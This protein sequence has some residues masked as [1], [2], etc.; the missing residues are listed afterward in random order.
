MSTQ[1]KCVWMNRVCF[2]T[3]GIYSASGL[4]AF[5]ANEK[6]GVS[7]T[8]VSRPTGPGSIQ[9]LGESF[10][11]M[12]NTGTA[13]YTVPIVVP[14]ASA[15]STPVL[16][17]S[18]DGGFENGPMGFGWKLFGRQVKR[19][20]DRGVPLYQEPESLDTFL[21]MDGTELVQLRGDA[22]ANQDYFLSRLEASFVRYRRLTSEAQPEVFWWEARAKDGRKFEFGLSDGGRI[23][24]PP[25]ESPTG[26]ARIFSWLLER[27]T[28]LNGNVIE[29]RYS[30][31]GR[32]ESHQKYL[33]EMRYGPALRAEMREESYAFVVFDYEVRPDA[34]TDCRSGFEVK[35]AHRLTVITVG[36]TG[37][38]S[39]DNPNCR[40]GKDLNGDGQGDELVRRY[41]L[42]YGSLNAQGQFVAGHSHWSLLTQVRLVGCDGQNTLPPIAFRYA[43]LDEDFHEERNIEASDSDI[44][45]SEFLCPDRPPF[46]N[47]ESAVELVDLNSDGLTD[48]LYT[49]KDIHF[50][51]LNQGVKEA[52]QRLQWSSQVYPEVLDERH[53]PA[54][55]SFGVYEELVHLSDMNGDGRSDLVVGDGQ[56]VWYYSN[57]GR[58]GLERR[59]GDESNFWGGMVQMTIN[60]SAPP[61]PYEQTQVGIRTID[62]NFDKRIDIVQST[63]SYYSV[64]YNQTDDSYSAEKRVTGAWD[65]NPPG[66]RIIIG[67]DDKTVRLA[68]LNGDRL[69]DVVRIDSLGGVTYIT[70][71]ASLGWGEFRAANR[72]RLQDDVYLDQNLVAKADFKDLDGN[73]LSDLVVESVENTANGSVLWYW[74]NLGTNEFSKRR[75]VRGL[76]EVITGTKVSWADMNG[77][78]TVDLVYANSRISGQDCACDPNLGVCV[79]DRLQV[80]D[81]GLLI[82]KTPAPC[83]LTGIDNGIGLRTEISYRS[84]SEYFQDAL[85]ALVR[86]PWTVANANPVNVV[87]EILTSTALDLDGVSGVDVQRVK[88]SYRDGYYDQVRRQF[89][90]FGFVKRTIYGDE[91]DGVNPDEISGKALVERYRFHNGAPDGIDND[92]DSGVFISNGIDDDGDG[93]KDEPDEARLGIDEIDPWMGRE[94]EALKGI[95]LW[96]EKVSLSNDDPQTDGKPAEDRVIFERVATPL[97]SLELRVLS[98]SL[99]GSLAELLGEKYIP[100]RSDQWIVLPIKHVEDRCV[101]EQGRGLPKHIRTEFDVDAIGEP[102]Y[103]LELGEYGLGASTKDDRYTSFEYARSESNWILAEKSRVVVRAGDKDGPF[104]SDTRFYYDGEP[105]VGLPR[106]LLGD[107]ALLHRT[108]SF[109]SEPEDWQHK[110]EKLPE[111]PFRSEAVGDPRTPGASVDVSRVDYDAY[112]NVVVQLDANGNRREFIYDQLLHTHPTTEK[113]FTCGPGGTLIVSASYLLGL[114]VIHEYRDFNNNVTLY[115]YD[116]FGRLTSVTQ[117]LD[118]AAHPTFVYLYSMANPQPFPGMEPISGGPQVQEGEQLFYAYD[119]EG[120]LNLSRGNVPK[121]SSIQLFSREE[122]GGGT[123]D[124]VHYF[125]GAG[126]QLAHVEESDSAGKWIVRDAKTLNLRGTVRQTLQP[127]EQEGSNYSPPAENLAPSI[128]FYYDGMGRP[129]RV[130]QPAVPNPNG[131]GTVRN[132][133]EIVYLPLQVDAKDEEDTLET[134]LHSGTYQSTVTDGL[135]RTVT[136]IERNKRLSDP[137][138]TATEYVTT[139]AWNLQDDL[140]SV[141]DAFDNVRYMRYDGLGRKI[142][143]ND[144]DAGRCTYTYDPAGNVLVRVDAK[145]QETRYTYDCANRLLTRNYLDTTRDPAT[146]PVDVVLTYDVSAENVDQGDG[147]TATTL[148]PRGALVSIRDLSG[149]THSS[150]DA[151]GRLEWAV[152]IIPDPITG[153]DVAYRTSYV[154]DSLDRMR[155]VIYPDNDSVVFEYNQRS[156]LRS[157]HGGNDGRAI[158]KEISYLPSAKLSRVVAGNDVSIEYVYDP[159]LRLS[160]LTTRGAGASAGK[161]LI[162]YTYEFDGVSNL[163]AIRDRRGDVEVQD[164]RHNSQRFEYDDLYRLTAYHLTGPQKTSPIRQ[165]IQYRYDRIGNILYQGPPGGAWRIDS[166]STS[167]GNYLYSG[168][169]SGRAP[170]PAHP[171]ENPAGPHAV[172]ATD[173]GRHYKYDANG[174]ATDING[175]EASWDFLDQL[176]A[177]KRP[178]SFEAH[179]IYDHTGRRVV[180][181]VARGTWTDTVLYVNDVFEVREGEE[182]TKYVF[183][184]SARMARVKG[185]LDPIRPRIQRLRLT[186]G[187]NLVTLCVEPMDPTV[188]AVFRLGNDEGVFR[189]EGRSYTAMGPEET[190]APGQVLWVYVA[191]PRMLSIVGRYAPKDV[192]IPIPVGSTLVAWPRLEALRLDAV[193][194]QVD[195]VWSLGQQKSEKP[196]WF[197]ADLADGSA[198]S[199]LLGNLPPGV[200]VWAATERAG[201]LK[202]AATKQQDVVFFHSDHLGSTSVMTDLSGAVVSDTVFYPYG[203]TRHEERPLRW[204]DGNY[205][206][207]GKERD[208]E[209]HLDYLGARY[210]DPDLARFL[211]VDPVF[212]DFDAIVMQFHS[213]DSAARGRH[214]PQQLNLYSYAGNSPASNVDFNGLFKLDIH[215]MIIDE[216]ASGLGFNEGNIRALKSGVRYND[217]PLGVLGAVGYVSK[218]ADSVVSLGGLRGPSMWESHFGKYSFFHAMVGPNDATAADVKSRMMSAAEQWYNS[219]NLDDMG[220]LI[221][222]VSDS[223][224]QAHVLR[225]NGRIAEFFDYGNQDH[226]EHSRLDKVLEDTGPY[227]DAVAASR[228]LLQ[229]YQSGASWEEV[230]RYLDK[231]VFGLAAD[232]RIDRADDSSGDGQNSYL[233]K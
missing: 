88:L 81:L 26:R 10:E 135:G 226:S 95:Q 78:G 173:S 183:A 40:V 15:G 192:P 99:G 84:S 66:A 185:T 91:R 203:S 193:F 93:E 227:H 184:G 159:R 70:Y 79:S 207:A 69:V 90:G 212:A 232:A 14:G 19:Q 157:V 47:D 182:P 98:S 50:A 86:N 208:I 20:V 118:S 9:G 223:Y 211:S 180:K 58:A 124:A 48:L 45:R 134:G 16:N 133:A 18:Y 143:K 189:P 214:S 125:D 64:W 85:S 62:L 154:L 217:L 225:K 44:I 117:P 24:Q 30:D 216:A 141:T 162:H 28:D 128:D 132:R 23:F 63:S 8:V 122:A 127:Y 176:I 147:T 75:I 152:K 4:G 129:I 104:V 34:F 25:S 73:G 166:S 105:F 209:S 55:F 61:P 5:A 138:D 229:M 228:R 168:G 116:V 96:V 197:V 41:E 114:D 201:Q 103:K 102:L 11:P 142:F 1:R 110:G 187:W 172:T 151:R 33:V 198:A 6:D 169:T 220:K 190:I 54:E 107:R 218:L 100:R 146:D 215:E 191:T 137:G 144:T 29:Y 72:I 49:P 130:V 113:I 231:D 204:F 67:L 186:F 13:K 108:E 7:P 94:E 178:G 163:T 76:P 161:E 57:L 140:V 112:G 82:N 60:G 71:F 22:E 139:Y 39:N 150:F 51:F 42:S 17:L 175:L 210:F 89:C 149:K 119:R 213:I 136:V 106:G 97:D 87:S 32:P 195:Q 121:V 115:G 174:N 179:Y 158:A 164:A 221:H 65:E 92:G 53:V 222:M 37:A 171:T 167:L 36:V 200:A 52:P 123:L 2:V 31:L 101:I 109:I 177:L 43:A 12:L 56:Q 230:Q 74:I 153:L 160:E 27:E 120:K 83:V 188:G 219:G 148:N 21:A 202:P 206:F 46:L 181:S 126:R 170:D 199:N 59:D 38:I 165:S 194:E 233:L 155:E 131:Q 205:K 68:D 80:I 3:L 196:K 156:L 77:N 35:T 111:L 224:S 145:G